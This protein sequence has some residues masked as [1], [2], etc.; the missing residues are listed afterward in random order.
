MSFTIGILGGMGP[1]ATN[2]FFRQILSKISA[3]RDQDFPNIVI[4]SHAE[5]PDRSA[6]LMGEGPS[7]IPAMVRQLAWLSEEADLIAMPC[8][9]AHAFHS[10]LQSRC[11]VPILHMPRLCVEHLS[12]SDVYDVLLLGT[13]PRVTEPL[14]NDVSDSAR[15]SSA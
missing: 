4:S 10:L 2:H 6:Y 3:E 7:P 8:N 5:I 12:N 11:P 15:P 13:E 14:W 1:L 9:T